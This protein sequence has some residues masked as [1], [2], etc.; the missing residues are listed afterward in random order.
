MI[1]CVGFY[2][3]NN[4]GDDIFQSIFT[5]IFTQLNVPFQTI[6]LDDCT[7]L[8]SNVS[9]IILG[10][11]EIL[12]EYFLGKLYQL[13]D[14]AHFNGK[15][16]AYS[17][18]LPE[19]DSLDT[20]PKINMIDY[21]YMRNINDTTKL[22]KHF[23]SDTY[24]GYVPDLV[25]S[26]ELTSQSPSPSKSQSKPIVTICLARSII[27][28]NPHYSNYLQKLILYL[29]FLDLLGY[30]LELVPFNTSNSNI[31][32]D[33]KLNIDIEIL[34]KKNNIKIINHVNIPQSN[35][36]NFII[37][38]IAQSKFTICSRYHAHILS[39]RCGIPVIS[40]AHTKKVKDQMKLYGLDK[41]VVELPLDE[42]NRPTDFPLDKAIELFEKFNQ[43]YLQIKTQI[44]SLSHSNI[45][46]HREKIK[47]I[48][49]VDKLARNVPPY[50]I[51]REKIEQL[52]LQTI[53]NLNKIKP[54]TLN[55]S[56]Q[57]ILH[58]LCGQFDN[59]SPYIWGL[60]RKLNSPQFK[61]V[62]EFRWIAND[63]WT[64][65]SL[66]LFKPNMVGI[67]QISSA[68]KILNMSYFHPHFLENVH[69]SGWSQVVHN[70]SL[71]HNPSP[72]SKRIIFDMF[73]DKTFHWDLN[74]NEKLGLIPYNEPWIGIVHHTPSLLY[75]QFN[76]T[77][78]INKDG[79]KQS[80]KNCVGIYTLSDW[81]T[82]WFN[83]NI[84]TL[85]VE[86][87]VH[88]METP[89]ILFSYDKFIQNP[90]KQLIQIGGWLRNPYSI[91][92]IEVPD[93]IQ[94]TILVGSHMENY[95]KPNDTFEH[96]LDPN[97]ESKPNL[98]FESK[99][100]LEFNPNTISND[101][102]LN[103]F[104]YYMREYVQELKSL[105]PKLSQE[106]I[107]NNLESAYARVNIINKLSNDA[108]DHLL[109][110]NIVFVDY[111]ELSAS[112]TLEECIVSNTPILV[113]ALEPIVERLG[114]N[115][116]MYWK[117]YSDIPKLLDEQTI[118]KTHLYLKSLD[119]SVY[120][121]DHWF[122]SIIN[123]KIFTKC[124]LIVQNP[125]PE[126][127]NPNPEP[128]NPN[129]EPIN[130]EPINPE[131]INPEPIN[132][133]PINPNPEPICGTNSQSGILRWFK[134]NG[135]CKCWK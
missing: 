112:N 93:Y 32:S 17:C 104:V 107:I 124:K 26:L 72:H 103:K 89:M 44:Q 29:K 13:C 48:L 69:R 46:F 71:L 15:I 119:K 121:W 74:L 127:I 2:F 18:E 82:K 22:Q 97:L 123:S 4:L 132:P 84:P 36:T 45:N 129:P 131:P 23:K 102:Q 16:I 10:G 133:E 50:Y 115:Y 91:Y 108:Y 125:N 78:M 92:R 120:T 33:I 3:R 58:G 14:Q 21:F 118:L 60:T 126:P 34:C 49:G 101:S 75:S 106:Q 40:L 11:G 39:I 94:P 62:D 65:K 59:N 35:K 110:E 57:I 88:P 114:P 105:D 54:N 86:T 6:N 135:F 134:R 9:T 113:Q 130:P 37:D 42:S 25:T 7:Q 87:L 55:E 64:K 61:H 67:S 81:M 85:T 20:I 99:S 27:N 19:C 12:N 100:N 122:N 96:L 5:K 95:I 53:N 128:I 76:T 73:V 28:S 117:T 70:T 77:N 8:P 47:Q 38:K 80:L 68:D 24:V 52:V 109:S 31:E 43:S 41:W 30:Q 111:I 51:D 90:K 1:L 63:Y 116:P 79:W 56:V 83:T 66:C 98:E